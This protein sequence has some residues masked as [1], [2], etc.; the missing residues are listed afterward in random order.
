M[1]AF[2]YRHVKDLYPV[3]WEK[4]TKLV[5][6]LMSVVEKEGKKSVESIDDAAIVEC[7]DWSSRATL[8]IIGLAGVS[9]SFRAFPPNARRFLNSQTCLEKF[10][11]SLK[12]FT[13]QNT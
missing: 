1:P 4:S 10:F 6:S 3:F 2:A 12:C 7:A 9:L 5:N 11:I 13:P 8:D